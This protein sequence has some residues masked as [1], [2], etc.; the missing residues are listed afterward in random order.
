MKWCNSTRRW[1]NW[2]SYHIVRGGGEVWARRGRHRAAVLALPA[3][4]HCPRRAPALRILPQSCALLKA[5]HPIPAPTNHLIIYLY[6][7]W[8]RVVTSCALN[9]EP[10]LCVFHFKQQN[11]ICT[12]SPCWSPARSAGPPGT[13]QTMTASRR[14]LASGLPPTTRIPKPRARFYVTLVGTF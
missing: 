1:W 8:S 11:P 7:R 3:A 6:R 5:P 2:Y 4:P 10:S 9:T 14:P 12:L 13:V